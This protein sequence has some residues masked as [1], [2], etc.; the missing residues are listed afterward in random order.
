MENHLSIDLSTACGKLLKYQQPMD[1]PVENTSKVI[2]RLFHS[3]WKKKR[4]RN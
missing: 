2:H 3:L 1:N 4:G